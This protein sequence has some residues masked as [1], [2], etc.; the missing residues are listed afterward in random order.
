MP[1]Q[2]IYKE[3]LKIAHSLIKRDDGVTRNYYYRECYPLFK[4]IYDNYFTDCH[5]CKEFMDEIYVLVISPSKA[6]GKCQMENFKGESSLTSWLKTVCLFYCYKKYN[7][8][9]RNPIHE[10][11]ESLT[12]SDISKSNSNRFDQVENSIDIDLSNMNRS[13]VEAL[14][15]LMPNVR[16]RTI[17]RLLY[18]EQKTHKETAE[19]LGLSMEVYYN[20]RILAEKQ[21]K[22]IQIK[23]GGI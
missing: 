8:K 22:Q 5:S 3:D 11:L 23:E 13:D 6:T 15:R 16:Y 18:L 2:A 9:R 12:L 4:S 17:I 14:L 10:S 7:L 20:K 19:A 1:T 21:F